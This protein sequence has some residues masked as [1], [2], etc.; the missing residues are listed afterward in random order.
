MENKSITQT[1]VAD[2]LRGYIPNF[3]ETSHAEILDLLENEIEKVDFREVAQLGEAEKLQRKHY[4]IITIEK[5]LDVAATNRWGI[6]TKNSFIYLYNGSFWQVVDKDDFAAFLGKVAQ[7]MGVYQYDAKHHLFR[8]ELYK[9]FLTTANLPTP[10]QSEN[11][12]LI[13]LMNGTFE[14]SERCQKLREQSPNDFLKYRLSFEYAPQATAP[15]FQKFLDTVLP[16][17]RCQD[18][19]SEYIGYVFTNSLKLE[20]ALILYGSGANGKS[21]FYEV[22]T[23]LLGSDNVCS[24][25]LENLTKSDGYQR[26]ELSNK[27]VNYASEINGKLEASIFKQLVSGEPVEA[28]Q[29]YGT[30]FILRNYAKMIFNCN[31]LPREVEHTN[32]FFRRFLIIP[33]NVTIPEKEQDKK[34]AQK[35]IAK[36]LAGVFNWV[37][38]G[39]NRLLTNG[40]L[41]ESDLISEQLNNYKKESDSVQMFLED[42]N[43]KPLNSGYLPLKEFYY[44]YSIYARDGGYRAVSTPNFSKRLSNCGFTVERK[45]FGRVI[46]C[47]KRF[48]Y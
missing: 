11:V 46:W 30:P 29:I 31:E 36:E 13:N 28:R 21:V 7:K 35:I 26:A 41:S 18:V 17:K 47:E 42:E 10:Q 3:A 39:L 8:Q 27:L 6:C 48:D 23:A 43:Y 25:S 40:G 12:T 2:E 22:I 4:S 45:N 32:A 19:L 44:S 38:A 33:F 34:L 9:Q 15:M 20:K 14:I 5:L 1:P 37:L 24:Y 16:D